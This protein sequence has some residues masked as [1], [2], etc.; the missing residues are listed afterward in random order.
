MRFPD[1][2]TDERQNEWSHRWSDEAGANQ[3]SK[4]RYSDRNDRDD[5]VPKALT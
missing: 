1:G 5:V 2:N 4:Y 3:T